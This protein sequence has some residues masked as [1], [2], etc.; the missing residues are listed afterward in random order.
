MS[1]NALAM[2]HLEVG[3]FA[4]TNNMAGICNL[5]A[6]QSYGYCELLYSHPTDNWSRLS[7]GTVD[8][9]VSSTCRDIS[10]VNREWLSDENS[11]YIILY[12]N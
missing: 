6:S 1:W 10:Y 11:F 3:G 12:Y 9:F 7:Q 5:N 2:P 4:Y 8:R